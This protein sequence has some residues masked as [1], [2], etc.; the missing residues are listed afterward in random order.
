M[1]VSSTQALPRKGSCYLNPLIKAGLLKNT[2]G[3]NKYSVKNK[4]YECKEKL[5]TGW[6]EEEKM[7]QRYYL[8]EI[9]KNEFWNFL[10]KSQS[11]S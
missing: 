9:L 7:S 4:T 1:A 10:R 11:M 5:S 2:T 3:N 8:K 6:R